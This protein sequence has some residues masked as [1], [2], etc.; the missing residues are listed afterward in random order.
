MDIVTAIKSIWS[1][2]KDIQAQLSYLFRD[3]DVYQPVDEKFLWLTGQH[4]SVNP[5]TEGYMPNNAFLIDVLQ[6]YARKYPEGMGTRDLILLEEVCY[7][8]VCFEL[9][10]IIQNLCSVDQ[11]VCLGR[12]TEIMSVS[13]MIEREMIV[14]KN[15]RYH[16]HDYIKSIKLLKLPPGITSNLYRILNAQQVTMVQDVSN[17]TG[18]LNNIGGD[19][20]MVQ[21][22]DIIRQTNIFPLVFKVSAQA[23]EQRK[24]NRLHKCT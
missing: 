24:L 11:P 6:L 1:K 19:P 18:I 7:K 20:V 9:L 10:L 21:D 12:S 15:Q 3:T 17:Y 16:V 13:E 2:L 22:E 5:N 4:L 14:L 23:A 8:L